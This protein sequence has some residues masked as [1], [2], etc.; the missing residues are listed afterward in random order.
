[1]KVDA[2]LMWQ[3]VKN[4]TLYC[5]AKTWNGGEAKIGVGEDFLSVMASDD[6][7]SVLTTV[8][9]NPEGQD[10]S[11]LPGP[12]IYLPAKALKGLEQDL[13]GAEGLI[14]LNLH[15]AAVD[16][17]EPEWWDVFEDAFA[18]VGTRPARSKTFEVNP[19]RYSRL[20]LLEPKPRKKDDPEWPLSWTTCIINGE[21]VQAFRYGP[22]TVGIVIPLDRDKMTKEQ[23]Q[24]LW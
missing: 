20:A 1:M 15:D 2:R 10:W 13:S 9:F 23:R 16:P 17:A 12:D 4:A 22:Y 14:A 24:W 7:V 21:P 8:P 11:T 3:A 6:F 5:K 18:K 19:A